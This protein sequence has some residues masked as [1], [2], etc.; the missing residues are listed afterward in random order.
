MPF[1]L[2]NVEAKFQQMV[3]NLFSVQINHNMK[4]YI[5]DLTVKS[6]KLAKLP[7]DL[8]ETFQR[9]QAAGIRLNAKKFVFGVPSGTC[10]GFIV[11]ERGIEADPAK[12]K[13]IQKL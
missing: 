10:L 2:K 6:K 9:I 3:N 4:V 1:G 13:D 5:D 8:I 12:I 11:Y 7:T